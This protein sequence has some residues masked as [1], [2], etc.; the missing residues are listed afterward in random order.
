MPSR[1]SGTQGP[2]RP[3]LRGLGRRGQLAP[4]GSLPGRYWRG[5]SGQKPV[6]GSSRVVDLEDHRSAPPNNVSSEIGSG[7]YFL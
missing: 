3:G 7:E 2:D 6:P 4:P 5:A 1:Q